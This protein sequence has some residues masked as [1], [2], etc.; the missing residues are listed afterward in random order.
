M[1]TMM[2]L[3]L[4]LLIWGAASMNAKVTIGADREP[5]TGAVW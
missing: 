2:L 1:K 5:A 3:M 4:T